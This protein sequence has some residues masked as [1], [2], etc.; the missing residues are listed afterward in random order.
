MQLKVI[1]LSI[2]LLALNHNAISSVITVKLVDY[3]DPF[4]CQGGGN[5]G[6][7]C[8]RDNAKPILI[9]IRPQN[10]NFITSM[11]FSAIGNNPDA[12]ELLKK[13]EVQEIKDSGQVIFST[14]RGF[15]KSNKLNSSSSILK[16]QDIRN[17]KFNPVDYRD[18]RQ[19]PPIETEK[20]LKN[21]YSDPDLATLFN[22]RAL[23]ILKS[24]RFRKKMGC[25]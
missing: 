25:H 15:P 21:I 8:P 5:A 12:L 4:I 13:Y 6:Y 23:N 16:N 3:K 17:I 19:P 24:K 2:L 1:V 9:Y 11:S 20:S 10:P 14:N 7:I 18:Y 22:S